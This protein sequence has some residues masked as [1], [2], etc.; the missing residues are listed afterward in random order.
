MSCLAIPP[1]CLAKTM[2]FASSYP[3]RHPVGMSVKKTLTGRYLGTCVLCTC[4]VALHLD[5]HPSQERTLDP[6]FP[7]FQIRGPAWLAWQACKL[8]LLPARLWPACSHYTNANRRNL[9]VTPTCLYT[10]GRI[11]IPWYLPRYRGGEY[12]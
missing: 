6:L 11:P 12:V 10:Q 2:G 5:T 7:M 1:D 4:P 8:L 3:Y 9:P